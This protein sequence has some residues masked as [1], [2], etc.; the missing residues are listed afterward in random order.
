M[1]KIVILILLALMAFSSQ[2]FAV[3][4]Y[5]YSGS[6]QIGDTL[7]V[8]RIAP[9]TGSVV[10]F[11]TMV[12]D[13]MNVRA[14]NITSLTFP[15]KID[16]V[17]VIGLIYDS[18]STK[19]YLDTTELVSAQWVRF[20]K[21]V[22]LDTLSTGRVEADT[23]NIGYV[24]SDTGNFGAVQADTGIFSYVNIQSATIAELIETSEGRIPFDKI[25]FYSEADTPD[26][27][28]NNLFGGT[29][30]AFTDSGTGVVID[31]SLIDQS[32]RFNGSP[33]LIAAPYNRDLVAETEDF[34]F[35]CFFTAA[36]DSAQTIWT[37]WNDPPLALLAGWRILVNDPAGTLEL[38]LVDDFATD[39][40]ILTTTNAYDDGQPH[41]LAVVVDSTSTTSASYTF[42]VDDEIVTGSMSGTRNGLNNFL[43][44]QE[45]GVGC[46][47][48]FGDTRNYLDGSLDGIV[49][50]RD[51][52]LNARQVEALKI[53]LIQDGLD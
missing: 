18:L 3:D 36:A 7:F 6:F 2:S 51:A 19:F 10:S 20:I 37:T 50:F 9:L 35:A 41:F 22:F 43:S 39:T 48:Q 47:T 53:G 11:D 44:D 40:Q 25:V 45:I 28:I 15:D 21:N 34:T 30:Y 38:T 14:I 26:T 1:K 16:S 49:Y 29:D 13:S 42:Y 33:N 8:N 27:L 23:G 17:G 52:A 32:I 46:Q 4:R 12:V 5:G 31:T 24:L